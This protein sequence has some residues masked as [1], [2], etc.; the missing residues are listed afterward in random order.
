MQYYF[1]KRGL[2]CI[3]GVPGGSAGGFAIGI[4]DEFI[5]HC[6]TMSRGQSLLKYSLHYDESILRVSLG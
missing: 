6:G 1:M 4:D 2:R 3:S 5:V